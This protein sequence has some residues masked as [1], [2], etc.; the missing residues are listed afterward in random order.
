MGCPEKGIE[1]T[2][3]WIVF[4]YGSELVRP[5]DIEIQR[6][7][8]TNLEEIMIWAKLVAMACFFGPMIWGFME[9]LIKSGL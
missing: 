8:D 5:V 9:F 3:G 6:W 1:P 7:T 2:A 4:D